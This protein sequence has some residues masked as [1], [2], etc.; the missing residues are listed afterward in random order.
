MSKRMIQSNASVAFNAVVT[1][2]DILGKT[3]NIVCRTRTQIKQAN[4]FLSMFKREGA[5]VKALASQYNVKMGRFQNVRQ[6][7][8][9]IVMIGFTREAARR[10]VASSL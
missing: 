4:A 9:D 6:L 8:N 2:T 3:H 5:T 10:I 1:Y 7:M